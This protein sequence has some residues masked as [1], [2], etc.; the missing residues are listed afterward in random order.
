MNQWKKQN[1]HNKWKKRREKRKKIKEPLITEVRRDVKT[2]LVSEFVSYRDMEHLP[3]YFIK[4]RL[5]EKLAK[6]IIDYHLYNYK[7]EKD[8]LRIGNKITA[9]LEVVEPIE[10]W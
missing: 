7:I 10:R 2:L 1:Y 5:A 3:E 4:N 8:Y 6:G 9:W